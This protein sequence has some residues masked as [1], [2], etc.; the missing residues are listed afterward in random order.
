MTTNAIQE[1]VGV[2]ASSEIDLQVEKLS[3]KEERP[4]KYFEQHVFDS[5][6]FL[7]RCMG[8]LALIFPVVL[9]VSGLLIGVQNGIQTSMSAYYWAQASDGKST[10]DLFVGFLWAIG[11]F[12]ILYTGWDAKENRTLDLAGLFAIGVA[13]FPTTPESGSIPESGALFPDWILQS[14][15]IFGMDVT[16]H[17]FCAVSLFGCMAYVCLACASNTLDKIKPVEDRCTWERRYF[18]LGL[19]MIGVPLFATVLIAVFKIENYLTLVLEVLGVWIFSVYWRVKTS[20]LKKSEYEEA[21][22]THPNPQKLRK[23]LPGKP[24]KVEVDPREYQNPT[25]IVVGPN[26]HYTLRAKGRWCDWR[27]EC[28]AEGWPESKEWP[29]LASWLR[30]WNPFNTFNRKRFK[31]FFLLCGNVGE[32]KG[33]VFPIGENRRDWTV[34]PENELPEEDRQLYLFANDWSIAYCNNRPTDNPLTVTI[35]RLEDKHSG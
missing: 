16:I 8:W 14:W 25:G 22:F 11:I 21:K 29:K 2:E 13:M 24:T 26:E 19:A 32:D 23:L 30:R 20:E 12:L 1:E 10:G 5:Y 7:R 34:P 6:L 15:D 27:I 18:W 33:T 28:G 35:T 4:R 3:E 9:V 17:G 31:P